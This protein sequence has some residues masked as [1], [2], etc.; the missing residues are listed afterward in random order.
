MTY[1][2]KRIVKF[3]N[4]G[5]TQAEVARLVPA[6]KQYVSITVHKFCKTRLTYS[7]QVINLYVLGKT[8][9]EISKLL[10]KTLGYVHVVLDRNKKNYKT[11]KRIFKNFY[12]SSEAINNIKELKKYFN[13]SE[14][15]RLF[16]LMIKKALMAN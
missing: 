7:Q 12:L 1:K 16:M 15:N 8:E 5:H 14:G 4:M 2:Q 6:S 11:V 10:N 3:Y 13:I 9:T